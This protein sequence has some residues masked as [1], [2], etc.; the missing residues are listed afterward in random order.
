MDVHYRVDGDLGAGPPLVFVHGVGSGLEAWQGVLDELP[1]GRAFVRYDLRGHGRSPAPAGPWNVDD[2]V[3]DHLRLLE[4]LG[5]GTA[6]TVGFSLGG[7]IVQRI[8]VTRPE[9][10]RRLVVIGAVAGRTGEERAAVLRRLATVEAE[11]PAGAARGSVRR[12]FSEEYLAG[13]PDAGAE[14]V[15][16]MERLDRDA[17]TRA[18]RVLATTDLA[19][20]LGR[21]RAPL[22]AMT[23]ESDIGSPPRMSRLMADRTGG[24]AAV[25]P[26]ARHTVLQ[27]CPEPIAKEIATHVR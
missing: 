3:L 5:V 24:R 9:A 4:R 11:G 2:F 14:V 25:L 26:G 1:P 17:Y 8:A 27:E 7:L 22:L 20:D 13:H 18:Y 6:D 23:G 19:D 21:I 10:V 16:R 12:W 15:A